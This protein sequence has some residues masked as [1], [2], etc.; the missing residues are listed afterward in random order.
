M[1]IT[2]IIEALISIEQPSIIGVRSQGSFV[3][4]NV[5][6]PIDPCRTLRLIVD[7][8]TDEALSRVCILDF[9]QVSSERLRKQLT[10]A[11]WDIVG[12]FSR[13][14]TDNCNWVCNWPSLDA[15]TLKSL[16]E[17]GMKA[18]QLGLR[19]I[20][21]CTLAEAGVPENTAEKL[22]KDILSD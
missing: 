22:V 21:Q 20:L 10:R 18:V 13:C 3:E 7:P 1:T 15:D 16:V 9:G 8:E 4:A 11:E 19:L 5:Q 12:S 17:T 2:E 6:H 14:S